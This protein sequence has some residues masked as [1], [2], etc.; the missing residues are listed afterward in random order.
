MKKVIK[1]LT[2]VEPP[3]E[4]IPEQGACPMRPRNNEKGAKKK[5]KRSKG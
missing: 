4:V 3:L 1:S 5:E 2:D